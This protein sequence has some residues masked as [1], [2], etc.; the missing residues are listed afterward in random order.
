M[1]REM[2]MV[3]DL[4]LKVESAGPDGVDAKN[5][6][7]AYHMAI[8][9]EAGLI[10]AAIARSGNGLPSAAH[11]IRLTWIGHEFVD[12]ARSTANWRKAM[13]AVKDNV[14]M[15]VLMELLT[16]LL[17]QAVGLPQPDEKA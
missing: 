13:N 14:V 3:R 7:E 8:M 1:K 17:R 4:L 12:A 10:H 15:P 6:S 11:A 2:D 5:E 9:D 16:R